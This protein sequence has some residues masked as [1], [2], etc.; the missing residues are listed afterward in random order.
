[1]LSAKYVMGRKTPGGN[2]DTLNGRSRMAGL[3]R[4]EWLTD[5]PPRKKKIHGATLKANDAIKEK[6]KATERET[7]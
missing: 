7:K 6:A 4:S 2:P 3:S 5:M 1:M